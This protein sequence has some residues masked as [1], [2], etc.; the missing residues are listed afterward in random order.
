[1][2]VSFVNV[3]FAMTLQDD[4]LSDFFLHDFILNELPTFKA[5]LPHCKKQDPSQLVGRSFCMHL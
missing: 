3:N 2:P 5:L 4:M 1:M